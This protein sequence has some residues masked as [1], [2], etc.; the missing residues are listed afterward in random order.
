MGMTEMS[1]SFQ[2]SRSS[3][4]ENGPAAT[5]S[6]SQDWIPSANFPPSE[7]QLGEFFPT[8]AIRPSPLQPVSAPAMMSQVSK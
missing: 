2:T 8:V 7:T 3:F 6:L 1:F 5:L 4:Q